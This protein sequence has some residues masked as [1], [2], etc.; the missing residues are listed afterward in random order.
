[1]ENFLTA[2]PT[3][4]YLTGTKDLPDKWQ[5]VFKNHGN[6]TVDSNQ[7]TVK[8]FINQLYFTKTE[9]IHHSTQ[10]INI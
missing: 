1:M 10:Y 6:Y 4:Y 8:L 9:I 5:L 3:K 2:K 7:F